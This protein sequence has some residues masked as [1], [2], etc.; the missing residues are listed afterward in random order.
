[1]KKP[2]IYKITN[3]INGKFYYGVHN[4]SKTETYM[5]SGTLLKKAQD[6][7]GLNNFSKQILLWFDSDEE[8]YEYEAIIVNDKL[9]SNPNCYNIKKGGQ[10]GFS[11]NQ[12]P[13]YKQWCEDNPEKYK[14]IQFKR[15][16]GLKKWRSE[17]KDLVE[18]QLNRARKNSAEAYQRFVKENPDR[19]KE[20]ASKA[21]KAAATKMSIKAQSERGRKGG[22]AALKNG[23]HISQQHRTCPH[24]NKSMKGPNYFRYHGDNCKYIPK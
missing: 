9:V 12:I 18:K 19:V 14:E 4:G 20:I 3:D 17:N 13:L 6:K 1:M 7:Y 24:C 16:N 21:G 8:A 15:A 22:L 10:G 2:H 5:G 11:P 23:N